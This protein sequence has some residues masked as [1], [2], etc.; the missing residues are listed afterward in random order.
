MG[1]AGFYFNHFPT[2]KI[3]I[4]KITSTYKF[5]GSYAANIDRT[6]LEELTTRIEMRIIR[7]DHIEFALCKK[8][9]GGLLTF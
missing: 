4:N 3:N 9:M 6:I 1:E 5:F 7:I 8:F 2:R